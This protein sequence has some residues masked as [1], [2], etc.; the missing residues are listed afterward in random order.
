MTKLKT[1]ALSAGEPAGIGPDIIIHLAQTTYPCGLVV[2]ANRSLLEERAKLIN[3]PLTLI[4]WQ[5]GDAI[6]HTAGTLHIV[7][8]PL[9]AKASPGILD[10]QNSAYVIKCLDAAIDACKEKRA[11]AL[12][13]APVHKAIIN[14]AGIPFSGHTE[15]L[16]AR[17]NTDKSVMLFTTPSTYLAL[18]TTHLPL[19]AVSDAITQSDLTKTLD[20]LHD[21]LKRLF[22]LPEPKINVLGLNPH[23][24]E[25]GYLGRE[26]IDTIIPAIKHCQ[27]KG[28]A[29][30]G[31]L[32]ADTAFIN[33]TSDCVL[34][35]YHDQALPFIKTQHFDEAVNV[36]LGLPII[37]TS[38][39][40]GTA[41]NLAGTSDVNANNICSAL[42]MAL[43]L[44]R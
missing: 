19:K 35:M 26:E 2:F 10:A 39:D 27:S 42:E 16:A 1:I 12:V 34:A 44:T 8:I 20:I 6:P 37:R 24:G 11:D 22:K 18:Q 38:V 5:E 40:H 21:A 3:L 14:D 36:T 17:C 28:Y 13:T 31:P 4:D 41:L 9:Q 29:I 43:K 33:N 23:A 15:Y 30:T 25:N 32:P 7:D